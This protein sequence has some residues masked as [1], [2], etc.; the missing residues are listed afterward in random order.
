MSAAG[1]ILVVDDN[2]VNQKLARVALEVAGFEV[3]VAA[4]AAETEAAV[5][6]AL[7]DLILMDV[8]LPGVDGLTLTR[9]LKADPKT[10]GIVIVAL[11]AYA[12]KGDEQKAREAGCDGYIAKPIDTR[13]LPV[14]VAGHLEAR[15]APPA[16]LLIVEDNAP[17]AKLLRLEL[18]GA[19]WRVALAAD[20]DEARAALSGPLPRVVITDG[21][22]GP[23][24]DGRAFCRELKR[25]P[26]TSGLRV[27]ILTG[28]DL[29]PGP[30][31]G[32]GPD[33]HL[34][35]SPE[36]LASLSDRLRTLLASA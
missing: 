31:D 11:T 14:L 6:A 32:F 33:L 26:R 16:D 27:V 23:S 36:T 29:P 13:A 12:M 28:S 17:F 8:Q 22:L 3:R 34:Q 19:G 30:D 35:K 2:A 7:P 5:A 4:D 10:R 24:G 21:R 1:R 15:S 25:D 18:E 9:R 20:L